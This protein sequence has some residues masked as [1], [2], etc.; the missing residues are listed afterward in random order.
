MNSGWNTIPLSELCSIRT[1]KKDV[2]QGNP[3]G[4]F[5]FFT[6]AR[7]HTFSDT[8]SFDTEALLVAGNGDVGNVTYFN[9]KFE[10]YQRTYV[11]FDF[12]NVL[13]QFLYLYL[14]GMLKE[15][16]SKQK[17]GN[18]MPYIKMGML[19]DFS[20]PLP[21]IEEQ[22]RIVAIL[23][24]AFACIDKAKANTE[25]NI[26]NARELFDSYLNNIFSNPGPDWEL[27]RLAEISD[28]KSGGTPSRSVSDFWV[29]RIPWYS[30]G[31]LGDMFTSTPERNINQLAVA[32][33][34]AKLFPKGSLLIGMYDTAALK[35]SILDREAA[36]NQ[37]IAGVMPKSDTDLSFVLHA[38]SA[39]KPTIM[40][41]RSGVRQKNLNLDKIKNIRI[42]LPRLSEQRCI[43]DRLAELDGLSKSLEAGFRQK[44]AKLDA[45]KRS[46]LQ[47][48]FSGEL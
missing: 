25:K 30:S 11:L 22:R 5:P 38:I 7:E 14:S 13:P 24:E 28:V 1:G 47:K 33:S 32:N 6:C 10:V 39:I 36:F 42:H 37:A 44:T 18:T 20:V 45:L 34:S 31:E 19:T 4:Q 16:V 15:T 29:G 43:V 3:E 35:M 12:R 8:F 41:Q 26:Q 9:G 27:K 21:P 2:N 40:A 46:I 23:D 17:L 48:G